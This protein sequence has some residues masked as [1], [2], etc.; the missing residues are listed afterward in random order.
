MK[1]EQQLHIALSHL[2]KGDI[3]SALEICQQILH[4]YPNCAI[5]YRIL[6]HIR[7]AQE[8]LTEAA[9]AYTKAIELQPDDAAAYAHLAQLYQNSGWIDDA[10]L[11]YKT[12][13]QLKENWTEIYY[14]LGESLY[15]QESFE[16]AISSYQ[17]AISQNPQYVEA[18]LGLALTYNIQAQSDRAILILKQ[19][20]NI[21][22]NYTKFYNTLGCLLIE[23]NQYSEAIEV[24]QQAINQKPDWAILHNNMG[25][26]WLAQEKKER[27]ISAYLHALELQP[28]LTVTLLNLGKLYQHHNQHKIAIDYF[29]KAIQQAPKNILAYSDCGYSFQK[30]GQFDRA[31]AYYQKAISLDPK[32][33]EAYCQRLESMSISKTETDEWR[34][35]QIA[36]VRFLRKLQKFD[37]FSQSKQSSE[38]LLLYDDW[39]Q[40]HVHLGNALL[41]YSQPDQAARHYHQAL[42]IQPQRVEIYIKLVSCLIQQK[43]WNSAIATCHFAKAIRKKNYPKNQGLT[44]EIDLLLGYIAEKQ[45]HWETAINYYTK[46]LQQSPS[47]NTVNLPKITESDLEF[48]PQ[49][50]IQFT[51]DYLTKDYREGFYTEICLS[52]TTCFKPSS[53]SSQDCGGLECQRCLKQISKQLELINLGN[54]IY[55]NSLKKPVPVPEFKTFV[56]GIPNG[57]AWIVPQENDWMIC[58]AIAILTPENQLLADISREYPG[59][60]PG[61]QGRSSENHQVF[62]QE[63]LNQEPPGR[64]QGPERLS[65]A[66]RNPVSSCRLR[67]PSLR[68]STGLLPVLCNPQK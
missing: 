53:D 1:I 22:P 4:Q 12:A 23:N 19:A 28:N 18:Y 27:A 2:E 9:L 47:H 50:V 31:I 64:Y 45:Q 10:V 11:L 52:E 34:L 42:Q 51:K 14:H 13:I 16:E 63:K 67:I 65:P 43:Q 3:E 7:E 37:T 48:Q 68:R 40:F 60:L 41:K 35:A 61:C 26:A 44:S 5:A 66:L 33:V 30:Q 15:K 38:R 55:T 8:Q 25:Q 6:G 32:F 39:V 20:I 36:C 56:A 62:K 46:A 49:T 58:K 24:F 21:A 54:G 59:E 17:Q 57:R 29:Q